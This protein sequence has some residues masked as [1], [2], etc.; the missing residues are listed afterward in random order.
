MQVLPK[1]ILSTTWVIATNFFGKPQ[2]PHHHYLI[3]MSKSKST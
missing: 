1:K 2:Y 3:Q